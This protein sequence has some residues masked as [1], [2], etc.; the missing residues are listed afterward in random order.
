MGAFKNGVNLWKNGR[1][2]YV[3]N[4]QHPYYKVIK[5]AIKEINS[6]TL[7]SLVKRENCEQNYVEFVYFP[8]KCNYSFVGM[9]GGRQEINIKHNV[10]VLHEIGH[11]IGL[12]HEHQRSDRDENIKILR[13]NV[14]DS[15]C[16]FFTQ[17][18]L[19]KEENT[20]FCTV[21]DIN[22]CMHYWSTCGGREKNLYERFNSVIGGTGF[23][24]N[25]KTWIPIHEDD[26]KNY[27]TSEILSQN[28]ILCI[29]DFYAKNFPEILLNKFY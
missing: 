20:D 19:K 28:D 1:I 15:H 4:N 5:V 18:F 17:S 11:A 16:N 26:K 13:D 21:Y 27:E 2:P 23:N 22:S 12:I 9:I 10:R 8:D 25:C 3:L 6:K 24:R 14:S 29:N 7:V